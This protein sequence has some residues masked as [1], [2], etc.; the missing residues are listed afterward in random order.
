[1]TSAT[2]ALTSRTRPE[3]RLLSDV[4]SR[5]REGDEDALVYVFDNVFYDVYH[6]VLLTTHD[7][8]QAERITRDALP[9]LPSLVRSGRFQSVEALRESLVNQ[10]TQRLRNNHWTG[11]PGGGLS[12]VRAVLRHAVLI[13]SAAIAATGVLLLVS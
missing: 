13:S 7:R 3:T 10:A 12:G 1:M 11:T 9:Q 8:R 5:A 6:Y 2:I 4:V